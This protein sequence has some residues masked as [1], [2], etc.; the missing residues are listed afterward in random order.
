MEKLIFNQRVSKAR[1]LADAISDAISRQEYL[2]GDLLPSINQVS[3]ELG[4]SR[5]TV[6]KAFQE[7]KTKGVVDS[8]PTKGY[9]VSTAVQ[10]I[11]LLLDTYSPFK[12]ELHNALAGHLPMNYKVDLYFH[13]GSEERF[14]KVIIDSAG[15]FN[16]Y[17]VMNYRNDRYSEILDKLDPNKVLLLDFGKFPKE[18]FSY[19]CQGFD[20][21]LYDS[22]SSGAHLFKKYRE[23]V[24]VFPENSEHPRSCIPYFERFCADNSL[25]CRVIES[26][27]EADVQQGTA[28][29]IIRHAD[30]V[31]MVKISH[32]KGYRLGEQIGVVSYN[33]EPI[34]EVIDNGITTISTDFRQIGALAAE[35]IRTRERVQTYV[36]TRLIVRGSL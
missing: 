31:E 17:L 33:D 29:L 16:L 14:N 4:L 30:L 1:Q 10:H 11:L 28:Y 7:L 6:F 34:F 13:Q 24:L 8:T 19:V 18:Q 9:F 5:D 2:R 25:P 32:R 3:R 26:I 35:F 27:D 15:R 20:T 12:Y 23:V 36:P 22:M 21:T